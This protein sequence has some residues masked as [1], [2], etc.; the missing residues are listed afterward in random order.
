M[1]PNFDVR[2]AKGCSEKAYVILRSSFLF[3]RSYLNNQHQASMATQ[4]NQLEAIEPVIVNV[5]PEDISGQDVEPE[6]SE[7]D[8]KFELLSM[9][10]APSAN[11]SWNIQDKKSLLRTVDPLR[12]IPPAILYK[13]FRKE[14][15][16]TSLNQD[17]EEVDPDDLARYRA[18][19]VSKTWISCRAILIE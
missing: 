1:K 14:R 5:K 4:I 10:S 17:S 11:A 16:F 13:V 3:D 9:I 8:A 18:Q 6:I 7:I 2:T 15:P 12:I 19:I